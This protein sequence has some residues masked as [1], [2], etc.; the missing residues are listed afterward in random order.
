VRREG[1]TLF[2]T[3]LSAFQ[4][5]LHRHT[6]QDDIVVGS[7]IAGR[8]RAETEGLIGFLANT[9]VLRTDLSGNPTFREL[10]GRVREVTLGAHAHADLPFEKE[11]EELQPE[12]N[13]SHS[14]L[15]QVTF[16]LTN[17]PEKHLEL[18]G[19]T[20]DA[21]DIETGV[22]SFDLA[23]EVAET[24]QGLSCHPSGHSSPAHVHHGLVRIGQ[25]CS[26]AAALPDP[27]RG[28]SGRSESARVGSAVI[29]RGDASSDSDRPE[30][31]RGGSESAP[32]SEQS[33]P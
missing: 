14:P 30:S 24:L 8:N 18:P 7:P 13:L 20:I 3:L 6:G 11:V 21:F 19:L 31:P 4:T 2:M 17:T 32:A 10:L 26:D 1:A 25:D 16:R 27:P 12:R 9:L 5:L 33:W 28:D 23:L 22:S 29:D 15:F